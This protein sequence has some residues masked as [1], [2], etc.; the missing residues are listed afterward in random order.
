MSRGVRAIEEECEAHGSPTDKNWLRYIL[1]EE[2][3]VWEGFDALTNQVDTESERIGKRLEYYVSHPMALRAGLEEAHVVALRWY[4]TPVYRALNAPL[5]D[6][7]RTDAHPFAATIAFLSEAIKRLRAANVEEAATPVRLWRGM[8]NVVAPERLSRR[9]GTELAPLSTSTSLALAATFST[10]RNA[11]VQVI[12]ARTFM[13][14]GAD[15]AWLST[16][17]HEQEYLYPP[18]TYLKPTGK[19]QDVSLG[20]GLRCTVIEVSPH[21]GS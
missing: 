8:R 1:H 14:R 15:L 2:A 17:P 10:S 4:T 6:R 9:G 13:Q 5:R 11:L 12:N 3:G 20:E 19:V 7:D 18:C 16:A 21:M